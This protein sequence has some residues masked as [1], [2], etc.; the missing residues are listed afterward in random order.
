MIFVFSII[1]F[2]IIIY[3][4]I[5]VFDIRQN[6]FVK[7]I[8]SVGQGNVCL[9]F[10]DGPDP[11]MTPKILEILNKHSV[12]GTFFLIGKN[13]FSNQALVKRISDEGH[14]IGNHTYYHKA[15]FSMCSENK[16]TE[17]IK[18]TNQILEQITSKKITF[19]RPP[20]GVTNPK[21]N[22]VL[23]KLNLKSIGWGI[24]SLDTITNDSIKLYSKVKQGVDKGGSII[25]LHDRCES[26]LEI[27]EKIIIYCRDKDLK[28]ITINNA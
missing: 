28:L 15:T 20:F 16:M 4:I 13:A 2:L 14:S 25:L 9:T 26:T 5:G 6:I 18:K 21:I 8:N 3:L 24:R 19:F 17:E 12:K 10:D 1:L 7:S 23:K 27:L 22:T 11:I